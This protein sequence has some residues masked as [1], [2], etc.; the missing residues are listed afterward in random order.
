MASYTPSPL[1][2]ANPKNDD[3]KFFLRQFRNY[4]QIV[5][6]EEVQ[7]LPL[8]LNA[9]GRDGTD[10]YDGLPDPKTTYNEVVARFDAHYSTRL[11]VLLKRKTFYESKQG[12]S[13]P[14]LEFACRLRRTIKECEFSA[15][16]AKSMLRDIFVCGIYSNALGERLLTEDAA[17]LTF[18]AAITRAEAFER[19]RSERQTVEGR[20]V[21]QVKTT[22]QDK[23][24]RMQAR[25]QSSR[26][27]VANQGQRE[28]FRCKSLKHLANDASCPAR[29]AICRKCNKTGHF[30]KVCKTK[31][32]RQIEASAVTDG[33]FTDNKFAV[34]SSDS[35]CLPMRS[36]QINDEWIECVV[37][38]G[39]ECNCISMHDVVGSVV[40]EPTNVK[41][42]AWGSFSLKVLGIVN[43]CVQYKGKKVNAPFIV[44]DVAKSMRPLLS[45]S[46]CQDLGIMQELVKPAIVA[47][48]SV[49][50]IFN[51]SEEIILKFTELGIFD[52]IGC[53]KDYVHKIALDP[54]VKPVSVPARR[55]PPAFQ[56][57][58]ERSLADM[59]EKGIIRKVDTPTEW[60]SALVVT[61]KNQ[62]TREFVL[63]FVV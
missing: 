14:A 21:A 4:L 5:K 58:I 29:R 28:C 52:G 59:C 37:D 3:W 36:V 48:L 34:Y 15:D 63:I 60:C 1:L 50:A 19:A 41:L 46:I 51:N 35:Q 31:T 6:A 32:V 39:A 27:T 33:M 11:S 26:S 43:C 18:E 23:D 49:R 25:G 12:C 56:E 45:L 2:P 9:L 17:T 13:E 47:P 61:K 42:S 40:I 44:V 8:L 24:T 53:V 7:K 16:V 62:V 54:E 55:L 22:I 57:E 38:T 10:I 30:E 20:Y